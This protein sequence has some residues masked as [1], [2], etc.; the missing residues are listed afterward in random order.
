M[1]HTFPKNFRLI[2]QKLKLKLI[3]SEFFKI[4]RKFAI[5]YVSYIALYWKLIK[6]LTISQKLI[7]TLYSVKII[8]Y[9]IIRAYI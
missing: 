6:Q 1:Q 7:Y 8:L 4:P 2:G 3:S 5:K 9:Y